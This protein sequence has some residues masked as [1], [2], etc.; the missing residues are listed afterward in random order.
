MVTVQTRRRAYY[1]YSY[2]YT[3]R[4]GTRGWYGRRRLHT[5]TTTEYA[6]CTLAE[7]QAKEAA[8]TV[9][10]VVDSAADGHGTWT[11]TVNEQVIGAWQ[12]GRGDE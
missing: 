6:Q 9:D 12:W 3:T 4:E 10:N 5:E 7:V 1:E 8:A 2:T 11:V